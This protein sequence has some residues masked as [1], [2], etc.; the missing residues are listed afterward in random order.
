MSHIKEKNI[1]LVKEKLFII[2]TSIEIFEEKYSIYFTNDDKEII[3]KIKLAIKTI[4]TE[5]T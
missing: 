3:S 5:L 4:D 1:G 2:Q